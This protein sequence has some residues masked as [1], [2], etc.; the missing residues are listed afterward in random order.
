VGDDRRRVRPATL[1]VRSRREPMQA[2]WRPVDPERLSTEYWGSRANVTSSTRYC[3]AAPTYHQ[4]G[5]S[6]MKDRRRAVTCGVLECP[7]GAD[8]SRGHGRLLGSLREIIPDDRA[9]M[10]CQL[11]KTT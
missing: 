10:P 4:R 9:I 6:L 3:T 11:A 2:D 5:A 8:V 7:L 1:V